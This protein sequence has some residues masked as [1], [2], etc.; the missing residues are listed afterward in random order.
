[1][2]F[3]DNPA[4]A[5]VW[6]GGDSIPVHIDI[7]SEDG[8]VQAPVGP[9]GDATPMHIDVVDENPLLKKTTNVDKSTSQPEHTNIS[10]PLL[11]YLEPG[12]SVIK[13]YPAYQPTNPQKDNKK[14]QIVPEI[15]YYETITTNSEGTENIS[16]K[17]PEHDNIDLHAME[18]DYQVHF[19]TDNLEEDP[20]FDI[21]NEDTADS[22]PPAKQPNR[23]IDLNINET[24]TQN[25]KNQLSH[26]IWEGCDDSCKKE[27][28]TKITTERRKEI[29]SG[30]WKLRYN[31]RKAWLFHNIKR[32]TTA[33]NTTG[34]HISRRQLTYSYY[35]KDGSGNNHTVCKIFLLTTLWYHPKN[36]KAIVTAMKSESVSAVTP[37]RDKRGLH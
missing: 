30:F 12:H 6:P 35:L 24:T 8:P 10:I 4:Q 14:T 33:R 11:E 32:T 26:P 23:P 5:P 15:A 9:D 29:W 28:S 21:G 25:N 22:S 37:A 1:M 13:L 3:E 20:D 34:G 16:I 27:C 7:V 18:N 36:D 19:D 17:R 31:E 2:F